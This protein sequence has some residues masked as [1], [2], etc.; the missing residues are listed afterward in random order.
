MIG[1]AETYLVEYRKTFFVFSYHI[2]SWFKKKIC[3]LKIKVI[4]KKKDLTV[5]LS[6]FFINHNQFR[7][8]T[9]YNPFDEMG[10]KCKKQVSLFLTL[11][12]PSYD[13]RAHWP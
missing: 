7:T 6:V 1:G 8:Q 5:K 4:S 12:P 11:P 10:N 2:T 3:Y 9:R 13:I